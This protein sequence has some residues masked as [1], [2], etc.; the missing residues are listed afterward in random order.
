[1]PKKIRNS[2]T[3]FWDKQDE[4]LKAA[5][6]DKNFAHSVDFGEMKLRNRSVTKRGVKQM[7]D[8]NK[9]YQ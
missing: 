2:H 3:G 4:R 7:A 8:D 5:H 1:M 9:M 6:H